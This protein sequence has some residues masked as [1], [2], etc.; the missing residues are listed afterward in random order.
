M[1]LEIIEQKENPLLHRKELLIL[2]EHN[3][4]PSK[5]EVAKDISEKTKS[6]E[7]NIIVEKIIGDFGSHTFKITA[8]VY[9]DHNSKEKYTVI[10]RKV[11]KK[12][13]E[14]TKKAAEKADAEAK[15][16]SGDTN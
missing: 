16:K 4:V 12:L 1:K 13:A 5:K 15:S 8:K 11:R 3:S 7:E 2:V 6:P 14:E 10:P 9:K